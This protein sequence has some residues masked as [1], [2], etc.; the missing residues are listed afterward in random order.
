MHRSGTSALTKTLSLMGAALPKRLMLAGMGNEAGHWEPQR[1]V[2]YD[3]SILAELG[4]QW[5][6]WHQLDLT[7]LSADRQKKIKEEYARILVDDYGQS[8][9]FVVKDPRLCRFPLLFIEALQEASVTPAVI[10]QLRN[11]IE[12]V[13]SLKKRGVWLPQ[14]YTASDAALL[15][16]SH[17]LEAEHATRGM[18]RCIVTYEG[19][20]KDWRAQ[21]ARISK[22]L[23]IDFP[24]SMAEVAPLVDDFVSND[25]RHHVHKPYEVALSAELGGWISET[26][27]AMLMLQTSDK[28]SYAT[29]ILDRVRHEFWRTEPILSQY[30]AATKAVYDETM[31]VRAEQGKVD[32]SLARIRT[33]LTLDPDETRSV[34]ELAQSLKEAFEDTQAALKNLEE[35]NAG[36]AGENARLAETVAR[37]RTALT[38]DPEETRSVEELAQSLKS[39]FED[40]QAALKGIEEESAGT[41]GEN[42]RLAGT[43]AR[44]RAALAVHP[45]E[46]RPV[47][48]LAQSLK[49]AFEDTQAA[50]KSLEEENADTIGENSRLGETV[51]RIRTALAVHPDETRPVEELAQSLKETF[52]DTQ[53]ALKNLEK[54]NANTVGEN[55]RLAETIARIREALA[56][57]RGDNRSE[58]ELAQALRANFEFTQDAL[59]H[60]EQEHA[61]DIRILEELQS[62]LGA[63]SVSGE[64]LIAAT[65][66]LKARNGELQGKLGQLEEEVAKR[67]DAYRAEAAKSGELSRQLQDRTNALDHAKSEFVKAHQSYRKSLSWRVSRPIRVAAHLLRG[68]RAQPIPNL[69]DVVSEPSEPVGIT[70]FTICSRNFMAYARTLHASLMRFNP[71]AKFVVALCDEPTPPFDP[72]QEPF[73]FIYL[74][75]LALPEW[76]EMSRRYNITEFNTSIKPFIFEYIFDKLHAKNVVY[77]DPD[78]Y[79][80]SR[81]A[82]LEQEFGAGAEVLLTPHMLEPAEKA[83]MNERRLLQYGIY[84][85]GFLGVRNTPA[86]RNLLA[87]WGR[88]LKTECIIQRDEGLFVDQKWADHFPAFVSRTS[89]LHHPGY[90]VAYW[91]L[92]SR[93]IIWNGQEWQANHRPLRFVHFSGNELDNPAALSRHSS[94]HTPETIGQLRLLLDEYRQQIYANGHAR[95]RSIPY[96]FNWYGAS[97]KNEH[98]PK[99]KHQEGGNTAAE[100][101][102]SETVSAPG[103]AAPATAEVGSLDMIRTALSATGGPVEL[104]ARVAKE[105]RAGGVARVRQKA[106]VLRSRAANAALAAQHEQNREVRKAPEGIMSWRKK[107]LFVEWE[108]PRIDRDSGSRTAFYFIEILT[109]LGYEVTVLPTS[110]EYAGRYNRMLEDIGVHCLHAGNTPSVVAHLKAQGHDY[111]FVVL[112]RG[113]V[114]YPILD[115]VKR[116]CS[117]AGVIFNTVD[118]HFV[119]EMREAEMSGDRTAMENALETKRQE[120]ELVEAA[121]ATIVLSQFERTELQGLVPKANIV[122][123][124]LVFADVD[125]TPPAFDERKDILFIGSFPHKP[126]IDA[127]VY[128]ANEVYPLIREKRPDIGWHVVG[129]EPTPEVLALGERPGIT[130]HGF[131]DDIDPLFRSVR[132]TVAP[133]RYGAGI[134]G[135]IATSLAYGVPCVATSV[136]AEGMEVQDGEQLVVADGPAEMAEAILALYEDRDRWTRMSTAAQTAAVAEY[137]VAAN[138]L[139]VSQMMT[140]L[141]PDRLQCDFLRFNSKREFDLFNR[142]FGEQARAQ[143][144]KEI[145]LI[146]SQSGPF[147]VDGF[148]AVCGRP[149]TFEASAVHSDE[150][151]PDGRVVPNWREHLACESCN[152]I[153]RLRGAIQVFFSRYYAGESSDIYF[154]EQSTALSEWL[155]GT[156]SPA[157]N[158]EGIG[159]FFGSE[160]IQDLIDLDLHDES[161]DSI[162]TFETFDKISDAFSA[163]RECFRCLREQGVLL[164]TVPFSF[165]H[166]ETRMVG[167]E[168][169]DGY[170]ARH[171]GWDF[172]DQLKQAG[173]P[174]V[175]VFHFWSRDLAYLG[176]YGFIFVARKS[177][178]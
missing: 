74:D 127:V 6:D 3:D 103:E 14:P 114:V 176:P 25:L 139:R 148:C 32:E 64:E 146:P 1:L 152:F 22:A 169:Q 38:L 87:W 70:Y 130:V 57:N 142:A 78:I 166:Q 104:V 84:N 91:N 53:A 17:V 159:K 30:A 42:S 161:L 125:P 63:G 4:S 117:D 172:I 36:T 162:L 93:K 175:D 24:A 75:D 68:T 121:D 60:L 37:I 116:H 158:R 178:N 123:L 124:P 86:T 177:G 120:L 16:L 76:R 18:P 10:L 56:T 138:T 135:K 20:L 48:E 21:I 101:R 31:A 129:S 73:P 52:E 39:A 132:A 174:R 46:T 66:K 151:L 171:F 105:V 95:Y 115:L 83:E 11:P 155:N 154:S 143:R 29:A 98:T 28:S 40:T 128:F 47:E 168:T 136:A 51:M 102:G 170:P 27:D 131:V 173:F 108:I 160:K 164:F 79:I 15:W 49:E 145:D 44:I 81:F 72:S 109:L 85:L 19:F 150:T 2:E 99:P 69:P 134:K 147:R 13:E 111:D 45:D 12:V 157:L 156:N 50:L 23:N 77:L 153:M 97:G 33:A 65:E 122:V 92:S 106:R 88:R 167:A 112:N 35:E 144:E 58:E 140:Q 89:I 107:I 62:R 118:L 55:S 94:E 71:T 137:S 113:P 149:S 34:E 165:D 96:A 80:V 43:V 41:A 110:L 9:L 82:E 67:Q 61:E 8:E 7:R 59:R 54:E 133:L 119:R 141:A 126:N 163:F 26:F 100:N 90:N 5:H